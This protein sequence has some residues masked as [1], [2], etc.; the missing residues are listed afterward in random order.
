MDNTTFI[1]DGIQSDSKGIH[2]I[3]LSSGFYE[4][5]FVSAQEIIEETNRYGVPYFFRTQ[6]EPMSFTL[7]FSALEKEMTPE[8]KHEVANWLIQNEYKPFQTTDDLGK[9]YNVIAISDVEFSSPGTGQ[10]YFTI[11]FRCDAPWAWSV[12]EFVSYDFTTI[13]TP[14]R[15]SITN[16][17]NV[18]RYAFP[19][20]EFHMVEG[21][22]F[23]IVNLSD[24]GRE[25]KFFGLD[26]TDE[27]YVNNQRNQ[28]ISKN[29]HMLLNNFNKKW[30]RLVQGENTLDVYNKCKLAL[31][32]SYPMF[33]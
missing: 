22:E 8:Y 18:Y 16:L 6:K 17:S 3:R 24:G 13:T 27:V 33:R 11:T 28:I 23:K 2:Q 15:I 10:G 7:T 4:T 30:L 5:P 25:F 14:E 19:E 26:P 29:G 1:F 21:S 12:P 20:L 9:V 32:I 31:R